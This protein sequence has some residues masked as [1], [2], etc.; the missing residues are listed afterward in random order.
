MDLLGMDHAQ[1]REDTPPGQW[2]YLKHK[3][4]PVDNTYE[5][6]LN[7]GKEIGRRGYNPRNLFEESNRLDKE[8]L[9]LVRKFM[10]A[11]S[12]SLQILNKTAA[13]QRQ[14]LFRARSAVGVNELKES[15]REEL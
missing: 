3:D 11:K 8:C 6:Y 13:N 10:R 14:H 2:P 9:R 5:S 4:E 1:S 15:H 12:K 7:H